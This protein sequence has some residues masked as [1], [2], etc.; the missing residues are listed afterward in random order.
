MVAPGYE[1]ER[2]FGLGFGII[3]LAISILQIITCNVIQ[4]LAK[5]R[6][7]CCCALAQFFWILAEVDPRG[8]YRYI[9]FIIDYLLAKYAIH[10][11]TAAAC[12][13]VYDHFQIHYCS[14]TRSIPKFLAPT[15]TIGMIW[16]ITASTVTHSLTYSENRQLYDMLSS[17]I[18]GVFLILFGICDFFGYIL[19]RRVFRDF[20]QSG[21]LQG[22]DYEATLTR[23]NRFHLGILVFLSGS[24]IGMISEVVSCIHNLDDPPQ[25]PNPE[26]YSFNDNVV[27]IF[28]TWTLETWWAWASIPTLRGPSQI[29]TDMGSYLQP[30]SLSSPS[31]NSNPGN[32]F[33]F[34]SS[35]D[36]PASISDGLEILQMTA[37]A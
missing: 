13:I 6:I 29:T 3:C 32:R 28:A 22:P 24:I 5:R 33:V 26:I 9:P 7:H 14:I 27:P 12:L 34:D 30:D 36:N 31:R 18:I 17:L 8:V 20:Q 37:T 16:L 21:N 35:L 25:W 15:L 19:I 4:A 11:L 1:L 23:L 2:A 10:S